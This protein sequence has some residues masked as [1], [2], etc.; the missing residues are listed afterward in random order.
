MKAMVTFLLFFGYMNVSLAQDSWKLVHNGKIVLES[1]D[2]DPEKN[3][4]AIR[5]PSFNKAGLLAVVYTEAPKQKDWK[6][7]MIIVDENDNELLRKEGRTVNIQNQELRSL[8]KKAK[9]IEVYT[10]SLPADP[11]KAALVR[12]RRVHLATITL[13]Q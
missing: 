11:K 1:R 10:M 13:T 6:R 8:F 4:F 9:A 7:T 2:E 3:S 12:V 5:I